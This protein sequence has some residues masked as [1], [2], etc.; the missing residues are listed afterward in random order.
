VAQHNIRTVIWFEVG[1]N[2]SKARFWIITLIV[3]VA[4]MVVFALVFLSNSSTDAATSAQKDAHITFQY[5]DQS[6]IVD[7]A[8]A[9][10]FG[11]TQT[12]DATAAIAAVKDGSSQAFFDFPA[13]PAKQNIKVY[14]EDKDVFAN[15]VYGSVATSLLQTSAQE[16]LDSPQLVNIASGNLNT[17]STTY[18]DGRTAAGI[19][20]VIGPALYLV[21]FYLVI[22]LLGN[23]MLAST[24]EEKENRVTEMI[25][26]TINPTSLILGKIVSLFVAGLVQIVVFAVPLAVAYALFRK[27]LNIPTLD[28]SN[29]V[30]NPPQMIIGALILIGGFA[31]FTGTLVALGAIMPTAKDAG[32]IFAVLMVLIFIP[33]YIVTLIISDPTAPI[34]QAFSWFPYSAPVTALLRNAFGVLPLWQGIAISVELLVLAAIVLRV[35]VQLFR[36]GSIEYSRR[37]SLADAFTRTPR[38]QAAPRTK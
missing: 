15:G 35:A 7:P 19:N 13:D 17:T 11:G 33:F 4:L 21:A 22:L 29:L 1:R 3:P 8:L 38:T 5:R 16:K 12:S 18:R 31:L 28:L 6:G 37:V 34:V 23:Q 24:L 25:L 10:K 9:S 20:G 27:Q 2:L 30:L 14:G 32:P 26:T 36:Y